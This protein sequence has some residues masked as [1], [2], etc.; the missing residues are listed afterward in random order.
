MFIAL[1]GKIHQSQ[2]F[3]IVMVACMSSVTIQASYSKMLELKRLTASG[4][5]TPIKIHSCVATGR[6]KC[7]GLLKADWSAEVGHGRCLLRPLQRSSQ[8]Q[9]PLQLPQPRELSHCLPPGLKVR[10]HAA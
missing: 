3:N 5:V 10:L 4:Q 9:L 6:R 7:L 1:A 2:G 8:L